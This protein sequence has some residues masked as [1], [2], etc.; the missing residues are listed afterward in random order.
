MRGGFTTFRACVGTDPCNRSSPT[1]EVEE[2]WINQPGKVFIAKAGCPQLT[3][4]VL[5]EPQ[6]HDLVEL[7]CGSSGRRVDLS[8]LR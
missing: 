3:T 5:D 4:I 8:P 6:V 1:P 2:I 7:C